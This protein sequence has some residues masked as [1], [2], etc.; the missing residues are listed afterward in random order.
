LYQ[1]IRLNKEIYSSEQSIYGEGNMR[2]KITWIFFLSLLITSAMYSQEQRVISMENAVALALQHNP[3]VQQSK[4]SVDL[5]SSSVLSAYGDYLPSVSAS[6]GFSRNGRIQPTTSVTN[7]Y[8]AAFQARLKIFDGLGRE[9]DLWKAI[10]ERQITEQ[11]YLRTKQTIV[12]QVQSSYLTVLRNEQL[13][14]V[15][16]ENLKRDQQQ[17]ERIVESNRV[18]ALAIGDVYRQ[19]SQVALDEYNLIT[20]K[21]NYDISVADLVELLGLDVLGNYVIADPTIPPDLD[22]NEF[23]SLPTPGNFTELRERALGKRPDYLSAQEKIKSTRYGVRSAFSGYIPSVNA[24]AGY[25]FGGGTLESITTNKTWNVGVNVS[26]NIFD[27]FLRNL[28]YQNAKV[29]E[30]NAEISLAQTE[31][32]VSVDVK[33]ALLEV[34]A[35]RK[36]YEASVKSVTSAEQDR[37]VAEEKYNLGSGTLIDLQV[38]NANYINAQAN[39]VNSV[40]NYIIAKYNLEYVFGARTY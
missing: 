33:K 28:S 10:S 5:S 11:Q 21:N 8:D 40:Y 36:Q 13:V 26:W 2:T 34:E 19:Q 3:T 39:K 12:Y 35:A 20:A 9:S 1:S 22:V 38:A 37:K 27:G 30:R 31:R 17:L 16:E 15:S 32:T 14:K 24:S 25:S 6:G 4:N 7:G 29:Q 23:S 18:G